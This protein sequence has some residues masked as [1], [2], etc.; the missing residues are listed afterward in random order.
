MYFVKQIGNYRIYELTQKECRENFRVYPM[1]AC[2]WEYKNETNPDIGN[3]H[4][5]ENETESLSEMVEWCE[6]QSKWD[7]YCESVLG[8]GN[9]I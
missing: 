6:E 5:T 1:F 2:W 7:R 4:Y 3:M 9:A 8:G